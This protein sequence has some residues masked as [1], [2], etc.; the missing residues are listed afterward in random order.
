[1]TGSKLGVKV[2]K[3]RGGK[4]EGEGGGGEFTWFRF[5]VRGDG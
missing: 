2:S 3:V 5:D 4:G 1:M